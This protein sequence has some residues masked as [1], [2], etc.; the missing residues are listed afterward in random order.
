MFFASRSS[1]ICFGNFSSNHL[2]AVAGCTRKFVLQFAEP[3][4]CTV[5]LSIHRAASSSISNVPRYIEIPERNNFAFH[6]PLE[7][8][9]TPRYFVLLVVPSSSEEGTAVCKLSLWFVFCAMPA[10][11]VV[12]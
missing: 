11:R 3:W 6:F 1:S 7:S 9:Y 4:T 5:T 10:V 12:E 2:A 8:R